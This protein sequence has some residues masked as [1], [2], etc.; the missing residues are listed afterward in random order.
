[1]PVDD[2][3]YDEFGRRKK[4]NRDRIQSRKGGSSSGAIETKTPGDQ[5]PKIQNSLLVVMVGRLI[6]FTL[7]CSAIDSV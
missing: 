3:G 2:S 7:I 5:W 1:M 4:N 6:P